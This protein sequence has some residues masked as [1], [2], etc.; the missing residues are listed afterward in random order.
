MKLSD[1][2]VSAA[3]LVT[4]GNR[5]ADIGT[6]HAY[7]PIY[8]V[9]NRI[10]PSAVAMDINEGPLIKARKHVDMYGLSDKIEIRQSDGLEK[11]REGEAETILIAGMGGRLIRR[12]LEDGERT[13][14][15]SKEL[16]LSPH[17]EVFTVREYLWS[18]RYNIVREEMIRDR[19]KY[20]TIIKAVKGEE[21]ISYT[22]WECLYGKYLKA[23][24]DKVFAQYLDDEHD[25]LEAVL[26]ELY[27]HRTNN[28]L[29]IEEIKEKISINRRYYER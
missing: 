3:S 29:R 25:K 8:L 14:G 6:D 9:Q 27:A 22:P 13:A 5:L 19:D 12:I 23:R 15:S 17:S 20:Y 18:R 2:L 11:L 7:V 28:S 24:R 21:M 4:E 16:I 1:R 26:S 10:I